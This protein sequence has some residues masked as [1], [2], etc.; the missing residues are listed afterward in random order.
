MLRHRANLI[1]LVARILYRVKMLVENKQ[2]KANK[3]RGHLEPVAANA[4][5]E[6]EQTRRKLNLSLYHILIIKN[7][8]SKN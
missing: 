4:S 1:L 6:A 2:N 5:P 3:V 8:L 7:V